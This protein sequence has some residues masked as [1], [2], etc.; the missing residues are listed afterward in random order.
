[1]CCAHSQVGATVPALTVLLFL[2]WRQEA[3][4]WSLGRDSGEQE[5][6]RAGFLMGFCVDSVRGAFSLQSSGVN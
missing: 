4:C 5:T 6:L 3:A 2:N 1:M